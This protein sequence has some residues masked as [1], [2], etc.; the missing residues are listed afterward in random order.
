MNYDESLVF[1]IRETGWT[2]GETRSLTINEFTLIVS[3]LS[4]Q[5]A[6]D[7]YKLAHNAAMIACMLAKKGTKVT[8]FIGQ[9]PVREKEKGE[10]ELWE[11]AKE[12][13]IK[14]PT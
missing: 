2:L 4:Y 14:T 1:I 7:D 5:K 11:Q 3:E 8:D 9:C 6:V 13:G 12:K 10:D